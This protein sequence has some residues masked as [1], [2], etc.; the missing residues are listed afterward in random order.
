MCRMGGQTNSYL[1]GG[2]NVRLAELSPRQIPPATQS[3]ESETCSVQ[4]QGFF[5]DFLAG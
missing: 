1:L 4:S 3:K 2:P 5:K